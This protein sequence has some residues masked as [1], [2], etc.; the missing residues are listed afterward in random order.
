LLNL[1]GRTALRFENPSPEE[2]V[3]GVDVVL[4][5]IPQG[6]SSA[7]VEAAMTRGTY[8]RLPASRLYAIAKER[9]TQAAEPFEMMELDQA[10]PSEWRALG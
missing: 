7:V 9:G 10:A 5:G 1:E 8:P 2:A 3:D 4:M 6:A